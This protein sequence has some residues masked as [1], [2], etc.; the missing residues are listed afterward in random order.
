MQTR[1]VGAGEARQVQHADGMVSMK[2][3]LT[4]HCRISGRAAAD[5]VR[6]GRRLAQLPDWPPPTPTA[7]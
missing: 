3:W 4:G 1:A 7:R 2:S 6:D 5:L